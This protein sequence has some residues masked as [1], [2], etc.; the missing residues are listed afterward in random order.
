MTSSCNPRANGHEEDVVKTVKK[1]IMMTTRTG[2]LDEDD[3]ARGLLEMRDTSHAEGRSP[4]QV[5]FGH[6]MRLAVIAHRR[7]FAPEWQLAADDCDATTDYF[8][9][10]TKARN[11]FTAR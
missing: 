7:S 8:K 1:Q 2:H 3:F 6:P 11:A 10:K 4:A 9:S 5:L